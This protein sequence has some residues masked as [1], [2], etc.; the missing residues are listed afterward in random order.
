[1]EVAAVETLVDRGRRVRAV[2]Y[3]IA[4]AVPLEST[5]TR[6]KPSFGPVTRPSPSR[7]RATN[8]MLS[9]DCVVDPAAWA[10]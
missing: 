8:S 4:A 3:P 5:Y 2:A 10:R 1:M 6:K 7:S 9:R